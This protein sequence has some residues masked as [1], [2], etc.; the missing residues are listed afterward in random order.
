LGRK[1]PHA[2][3]PK[4]AEA[5]PLEWETFQKF[6]V[7]RNPWDKTV[8]DY[9]WRIQRVS[10]PPS[11]NQYISALTAGESMGG[12][13]P[14]DYHSNWDMYTIN[15]VIAADHVIQF[16]DLSGGLRNT[17]AAIVLEWDS[18]LPNAKS[19]TR[20]K[21]E[22][23]YRDLYTSTTAAQVERLYA[24]EIAAFDFRF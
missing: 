1:P 20:K 12:I 5:F 18:W 3:A 21:R 8:S 9:F 4:V 15:D 23:S 16:D 11:F 2:P 13:V 24:K 22:I 14:I 17:L 10:N 19:T 7:V 6:C